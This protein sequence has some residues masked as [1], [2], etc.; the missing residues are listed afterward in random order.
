MSLLVLLT[1]PKSQATGAQ[2][3][4]AAALA[5][6]KRQGFGS[7]QAL[8]FEGGQV[9]WFDTPNNAGRSGAVVRGHNRWAAY[10]GSVHWQGLSGDPLL[11]KLLNDF[12][13]PQ[14]MPLRDF[15]GS[16][17]MV[18]SV[19]SQ[20]WLF[21]DAVGLQ[22]I[23]TCLDG[24]VR[25][26]SFLLCRHLLRQPKVDRLRAQEYVLLGSTHALQTP[27]SGIQVIEPTQALDLGSS[28]G[29]VLYPPQAWRIAARL[30]SADEAVVTLSDMIAAEFGNMRKALGEPIGMAL[31]GGFDSRLILAA[32]DH[33]Q[34]VPKL[35][36]YG[37][38][39]MDDVQIAV[40]KAAEL[41]LPIECVD[42]QRTNAELPALTKQRL[43]DNLAFFD[44]LPID[45]I[46]DRGADQAT[47]LRQVQDGMLNLNGGGGEILRNFFYLP[48]KAY[49][50]TDLV[51]AFY[52]NWLPAAIA[53]GGERQDFVDA[54]ADGI[55]SNLGLASGSHATR[56]ARLLRSDVELVYALFRL[57]YWMCRNNSVAARYGAFM[58]PL[59]SPRLVEMA[60]T[61]PVAW[62]THGHLE[63][64][65]ISRL[66]RR[67][68]RGPS[69]YGFDFSEGP[70]PEHCRYINRTLIRPIAVRRRSARIRRM[71]GRNATPTVP[72]EWLQAW[73]PPPCDWLDA[74]YLTELAQINRLMSLQALL[75]DGMCCV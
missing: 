71:L 55:L 18:F 4:R 11:R 57:R 39:G 72:A 73:T 58:T 24:G 28:A 42:K 31:S 60:A 50:A 54:T 9:W 61:V 20:A 41:G 38:P 10:T 3:H 34:V 8:D 21:N 68:A 23:Y 47:R 30:K 26:T 1:Y 6:A 37:P 44:G 40:A 43:Q 70:T 67:V 17:A 15:C 29:T 35:Y 16:F 62:K 45:G 5:S 33:H 36:V 65:I 49:C 14:D 12:D 69:N 66:S 25:S 53:D 27:I 56:H 32:L 52:S 2:D 74:R 59:V 75:D 46:F 19:G 7:H 48:D 13:R 64:S 22:K 63:A 51:G